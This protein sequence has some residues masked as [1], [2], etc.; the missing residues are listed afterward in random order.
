M[1]DTTDKL[2]PAAPQDSLARLTATARAEHLAVG[3]ALGNALQHA[4]NAGDALL[5]M[6][7][8]VPEGCWQAH[9]RGQVD[10]SERCVRV[11]MQVA[12]SRAALDR[13]SSAG[14]LSIAAA[15]EYLK[16][17]EKRKKTTTSSIIVAARPA[18]DEPAETGKT[19]KGNKT[20]QSPLSSLAWSDASIEERRHFL[21]AIGLTSIL[22][23]MPPGWSAVLADRVLG[24][25]TPDQ[26][27]G[28][29][30]RRLDDP[31]ARAALK[32]LKRGLNRP[33]QITLKAN[34]GAEE[35]ESVASPA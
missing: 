34:S 4:M 23:A 33:K 21:D 16:D 13:Q 32:D 8:L 30:E 25:L 20:A 29:L 28:T 26:L 27:I 2:V 18:P 7:E 31:K 5:A 14:P 24:H 22:G 9:L 35:S 17:P 11:Y 10:I 12:K 15:L 3:H 19:A 6:R 1:P